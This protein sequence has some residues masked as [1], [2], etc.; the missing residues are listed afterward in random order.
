MPRFS[1][2][3]FPSSD[4]AKSMKVLTVPDGIPEVTKEKT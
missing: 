3:L 4:N 2:I 1:M